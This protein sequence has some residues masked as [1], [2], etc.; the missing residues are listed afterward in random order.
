MLA[1]DLVGG[2]LGGGR[3]WSGWASMLALNKLVPR[4]MGGII[5]IPRG[6]EIQDQRTYTTH[7]KSHSSQGASRGLTRG[8]GPPHRKAKVPVAPW[9]QGRETQ[10][11]QDGTPGGELQAFARRDAVRTPC[12]VLSV[13][14]KNT[15]ETPGWQFAE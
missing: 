12:T 5:H 4:E 7:A 15:P 13:V 8:P 10:L 1:A 2:G 6:D 3:G 9:P 14:I 11:T